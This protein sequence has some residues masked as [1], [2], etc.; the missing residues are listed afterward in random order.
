[1]VQDQFS[2]AAHVYNHERK[3]IPLISYCFRAQNGKCY[4]S[5]EK[6]KTYSQTVMKFN[7]LI[8]ES[9]G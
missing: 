3:S 5:F 8:F 4:L 6:N 2:T 9:I 7:G 1:M